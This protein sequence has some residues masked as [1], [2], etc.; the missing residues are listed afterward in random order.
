MLNFKSYQLDT[1]VKQLE[2]EISQLSQSRDRQLDKG[3]R[4]AIGARLQGKRDEL[5]VV[6]NAERRVDNEQQHRRDVKKFTVF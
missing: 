1:K 2:K 6:K 5:A 4:E 3:A